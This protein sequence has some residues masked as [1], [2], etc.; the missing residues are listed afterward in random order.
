MIR[1]IV[2]LGSLTAIA[3]VSTDIYLP[4]IPN[5]EESWNEPL[6]RINLALSGFFVAFCSS[7]LLFGPLSDRFGRKK[8][9]LAG[10]AIYCIASTLCATATNIEQLVLYRILQGFGAGSASAISLAITKDRF[11]DDEE[12]GRV[13]SYI[14]VIMAIAPMLAPTLG[15]VIL[16]ISEWQMIF[17]SQAVFGLL[18]W[19]SVA[20]MNESLLTRESVNAKEIVSRYFSFF[21]NSRFFSYSM[22]SSLL[23]APMFAYI[24][25]SS[26]IYQ[27]TMKL[28]A[29]Q[30]GFLFAFNALSL[31]LGNLVYVS[32]QKKYGDRNLIVLAIAIAMIGAIIQFSLSSFQNVATFALPMFLITFGVGIG[33]AP[34]VNSALE[35]INKHVGIASSIIVFSNFFIASIA[36]LIAS[37]DFENRVAVI[38]IFALCSC[39]TNALIM[40]KL[41]RFRKT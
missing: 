20:A 30:Y 21:S 3:A 27:E 32:L 9:L 24:A 19:V 10:I 8:P 26:T 34:S 16:Q 17:I 12:R 13:L 36:M 35:S 39:T 2:F 40:L 37:I 5:L 28:G 25:A 31:M 14:A 38:A 6:T 41:L 33:R 4:A 7:I 15:A 18:L 11:S 22:I 1:I 23:M 29:L